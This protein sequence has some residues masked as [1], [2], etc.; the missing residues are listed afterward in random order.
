MIN[1]K[2]LYNDFIFI[3]FLFGVAVFV[4]TFV[5]TLLDGSFEDFN[6]RTKITIV[7][8]LVILLLYTAG[9]IKYKLDNRQI[10]N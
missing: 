2:T 1:K 7:A 10:N 4:Y 8:P 3:W 9:Y 5:T 6:A